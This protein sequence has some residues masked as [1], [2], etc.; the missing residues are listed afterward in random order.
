MKYK[1]DPREADDYGLDDEYRDQ[2]R[3]R[4]DKRARGKFR[5]DSFEG[6]DRDD[7]DWGWN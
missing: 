4:R 5:R 2:K 3:S 1:F 7:D 6:R